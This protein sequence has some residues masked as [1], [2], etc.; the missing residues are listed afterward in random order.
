MAPTLLKAN[1]LDSRSPKKIYTGAEHK[2]SSK[3][4]N[5]TAAHKTKTT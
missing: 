5:D 2:R 3:H 1:E 4:H